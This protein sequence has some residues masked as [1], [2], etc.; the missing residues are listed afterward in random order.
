MPNGTVFS[1]T[2]SATW[3]G[4][5]QTLTAGGA[6]GLGGDRRLDVYAGGTSG[7]KTQFTVDITGYYR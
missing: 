2:S 4:D 5:G 3:F 7:S 1:G 6:V